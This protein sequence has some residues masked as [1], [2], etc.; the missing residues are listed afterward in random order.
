ML[1]F[2]SFF[3][4]HVTSIMPS[5]SVFFISSAVLAILIFPNTQHIK[6]N[7]SSN[8]ITAHILHT[9]FTY[10]SFLKASSACLNTLWGAFWG[11]FILFLSFIW[12][13]RSN[14]WHFPNN[15]IHQAQ[16]KSLTPITS[17]A[18]RIIR[19]VLLNQLLRQ[20]MQSHWNCT[21][22]SRLSKLIC[23]WFAYF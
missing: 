9:I 8:K 14:F 2:H 6:R 4:T 15:E 1:S 17:F 16:K 23:S 12:F 10:T 5:P 20:C 3:S 19:R 7:G 11:F 18:I 13:D 22:N 21:W